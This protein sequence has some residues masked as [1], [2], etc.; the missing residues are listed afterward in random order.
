MV[1]R[2]RYKQ[3]GGISISI[4][5][6]LNPFQVAGFTIKVYKFYLVA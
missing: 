3:D 6:I 2:G 4:Q 1:T 5:E